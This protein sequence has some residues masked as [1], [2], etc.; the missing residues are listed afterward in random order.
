MDK[1]HGDRQG[2]IINPS[3]SVL[4]EQLWLYWLIMYAWKGSMIDL[5]ELNGDSGACYDK[6]ISMLLI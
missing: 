6:A 2:G 4:K 3:N 1:S 5:M